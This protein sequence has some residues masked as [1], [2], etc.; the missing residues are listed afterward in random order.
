[1]NICHYLIYLVILLLLKN[2]CAANKV[3]SRLDRQYKQAKGACERNQC[4]HIYMLD[5]AQ[6]CINECVSKS[7]FDEIYA[8]N[9]LED[10][11]IDKARERQFL[12][13]VRKEIKRNNV[14]FV[15]IQ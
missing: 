2:T 1:M 13:C 8:D 14:R 15:I 3:N 11:E 9:P 7:C 6:N 4:S 5:E 12:Q 10:G